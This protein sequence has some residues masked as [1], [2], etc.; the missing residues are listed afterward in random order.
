MKQSNVNKPLQ[1][2]RDGNVQVSTWQQRD[3]ERDRYSLKLAKCYQKDGEWHENA[4]TIYPGEA[5]RMLFLLQES[6]QNI[7][8]KTAG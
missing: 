5:A 4:L 2:Y 7:L 6:Y 3:K 1:V 8:R